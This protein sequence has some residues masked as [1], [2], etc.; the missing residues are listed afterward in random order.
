V[1]VAVLLS[2]VPGIAAAAP[3]KAVVPFVD[4]YQPN[5]DG[6]YTVVLGYTNPNDKTMTIPHGSKNMLTPSSLQ[7]A[8]PKKFLPGT[9][10]GAFS[11]KVRPADLSAGAGWRLDGFTLG[12]PAAASAKQCSPSTPLPAL[13]NGA[14][15]AIVLV[16]GGLVGALVVRRVLRRATESA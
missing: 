5:T 9:Q 8:Q 3:P 6:T 13:G 2:A 10:R 7:G 12:Y 1:C 16:A 14:G 11:V 4:C 15:I